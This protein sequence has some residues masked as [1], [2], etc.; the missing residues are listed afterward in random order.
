MNNT[1]IC[2]FCQHEATLEKSTMVIKK[3]LTKISVPTESFVCGTCGRKFVSHEQ[4]INTSGELHKKRGLLAFKN[5]TQPP[6]PQSL[7]QKNNGSK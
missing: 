7:K 2:P 4:D 6:G 3:G 1:A 5:E